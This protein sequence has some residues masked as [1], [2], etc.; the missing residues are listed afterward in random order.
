[1]VAVLAL[2]ARLFRAAET[3][4][5]L[6]WPTVTLKERMTLH[7]G[8][9]RVEPSFIRRAHTAAGAARI[10]VAIQVRIADIAASTSA[11]HNIFVGPRIEAE[12][13]SIDLVNAGPLQVAAAV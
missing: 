8:K 1:M 11:M 7:L 10:A 5:G 12:H 9:R 6:T 4:P 2:V 3:I 13:V